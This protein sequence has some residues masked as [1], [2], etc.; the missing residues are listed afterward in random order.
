MPRS[1]AQR[2]VRT[3]KRLRKRETAIAGAGRLPR[4]QLHGP[5][6]WAVVDEM[7]GARQ[8]Q[9]RRQAEAMARVIA[10]CSLG[11]RH[12]ARAEKAR[13]CPWT[14]GPAYRLTCPGGRT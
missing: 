6:F 13:T 3:A 10:Q 12:T 9:E 2:Q 1:K 11:Q 14:I 4:V 7:I 5:V 8:D